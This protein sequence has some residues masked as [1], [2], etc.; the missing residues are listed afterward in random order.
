MARL[1]RRTPPRRIP[2]RGERNGRARRR[3]GRE[4]NAASARLPARR[5]IPTSQATSISTSPKIGA[6]PG[7]EPRRRWSSIKHY[8]P[9]EMFEC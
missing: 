2:A 4:G 9:P 5:W 7:R 1:L 6:A 3:E 8:E